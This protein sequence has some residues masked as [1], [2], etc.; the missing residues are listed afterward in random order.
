[1]IDKNPY[2]YNEIIAHLVTEPEIETNSVPYPNEK[3]NH[4]N[5]LETIS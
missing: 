1:M 2:H 3:K 4:I 5:I